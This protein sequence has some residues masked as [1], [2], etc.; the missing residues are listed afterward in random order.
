MSV[1]DLSEA[2]VL[3]LTAVTVS[4]P[5]VDPAAMVRLEVAVLPDFSV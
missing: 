3:L 1:T 5:L 4:V 2:S